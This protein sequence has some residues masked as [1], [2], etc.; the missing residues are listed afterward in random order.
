MR[1][2]GAYWLSPEGVLHRAPFGHLDWIAPKV[3]SAHERRALTDPEIDRTALA[4]EFYE[5][6]FHRGY[7]RVVISATEPTLGYNSSEQICPAQIEALGRVA[8][9]EALRLMDTDRGPHP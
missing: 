7:V 5:R 3:A 8:R 4:Q 6:A 9:E 1:D 2:P